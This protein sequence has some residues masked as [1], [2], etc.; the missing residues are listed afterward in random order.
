MCGTSPVGGGQSGANRVL[1]AGRRCDLAT[2]RRLRPNG[3]RAFPVAR[4]PCAG[5]AG[6]ILWDLA[7]S[8]QCH[9]VMQ[10]NGAKGDSLSTAPF[11]RPT[12]TEPCGYWMVRTEVPYLLLI[13]PIRALAIRMWLELLGWTPSSENAVPN[14]T[15]ALARFGG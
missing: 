4:I 13:T 8:S 9:P 5:L 3:D 2:I 11:L 6:T 12:P 14:G 10:V 7:S 15:V 1:A